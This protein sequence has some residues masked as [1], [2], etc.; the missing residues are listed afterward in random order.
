LNLNI[1]YQSCQGLGLRNRGGENIGG[2]MPICFS[3][4][5]CPQASVGAGMTDE[6]AGM[7]MEGEIW[8]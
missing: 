2:L 6:K 4:F 8:I 3:A 5:A 7:T 1:R